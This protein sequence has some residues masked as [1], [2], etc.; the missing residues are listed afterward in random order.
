MFVAGSSSIFK[1][2]ISDYRDNIRELRK[3]I[4]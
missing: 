3:S 2:D 4:I 1:G